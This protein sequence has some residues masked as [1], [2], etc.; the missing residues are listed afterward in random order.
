MKQYWY[1]NVGK[2]HASCQI[3]TGEYTQLCVT[4]T[5]NTMI[6]VQF[7]FNAYTKKHWMYGTTPTSWVQTPLVCST[8][9]AKQ[10]GMDCL[11][12][13]LYSMTLFAI[14]SEP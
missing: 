11:F 12:E 13:A 4:F 1:Q 3:K 5:L 9:F 6:Y 2:E 8:F 7:Q 14:V 10:H